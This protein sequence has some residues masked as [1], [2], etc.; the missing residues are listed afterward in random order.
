MMVP[1][2]CSNPEPTD[3][4]DMPFIPADYA[5]YLLVQAEIASGVSAGMEQGVRGHLGGRAIP[6]MEVLVR[7]TRMKFLARRVDAKGYI[8]ALSSWVD[9]QIYLDANRDALQ[10]SGPQNPVYGEILPATPEQL[11]A[12][13]AVFS[14]EDALLSFGI[15]AAL[16][17]RA[18]ALAALFAG[19][20]H[21]QPG[22]PGRKILE[23]MA[24]GQSHEEGLPPY[25]AVQIHQ[26]A[27]QA[28]LTPD[29]LFVACVRFAQWADKSNLQAVLTPPLEAW[30]RAAWA[31]AI[32]EQR[33]NLR[34]PVGSVPPIARSWPRPTRG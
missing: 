20:G 18:D 11:L 6:N 7:G 31:H 30:A 1:G 27:H 22:Y 14:A 13:R 10:Q 24:N 23:V 32:E 5:R 28:V 25:V 17:K 26:V 3:L 21:I 19:A 2:M 16:Q 12:E 8:A 15:M 4:S 29:E 33:F 9:S 34:S